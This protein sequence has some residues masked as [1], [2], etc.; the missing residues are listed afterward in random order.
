MAD[1]AREKPAEK[2][3]GDAWV[4]G[5]DGSRFWGRFG[6]AGV[7]VFDPARGVLLQHRVAWSHMGGTWG[8]PGGAIDEHETPLEGALREAHEEAAV[9]ADA[10]RPLFD[11]VLDLGFWRYT[12]VVTRVT[13]HFD[14]RMQDAESEE[15][16]WVPLAQVGEMPLHPEFEK[17]WPAIRRGIESAQPTL[18]VDVANV[19]GSKPDGWWRDRPGA[20]ARLVEK[21]SR[22]LENGVPGELLGLSYGTWW[23]DTVAVVEGQA[24]PVAD[25]AVAR[26]DIVPSPGEGDDEIVEQ[27]RIAVAAA[28]GE[29]D[30]VTVVTAD[31]GLRERIRAVG[32]RYVGPGEL[33]KLLP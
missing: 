10:V 23:P 15:L 26:V 31:R 27:A 6:A 30:L 21:V 12:T 25:A 8:I 19:M 32:A 7:V 22:M 28:G 4:T 17:A 24:K 33:L 18:I 29:G 20:A 14:E 13:R 9:P 5:A 1:S 3:S 16:R 2:R 11:L